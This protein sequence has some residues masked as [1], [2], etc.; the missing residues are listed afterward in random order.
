MVVINHEY[1]L[2]SSVP[3]TRMWKAVVLDADNLI[4]KIMPQAIKMSRLYRET[5]ELEA[6]R[7]PFKSAKHRI[8][9]V[10]EENHIF[11]Y[12]IIEGDPLMGELESIT[13]VVKIE[14]GL[15]GE[16]VIKTTSSYITKSD[17]HTITED[18]IKKGKDKAEAI[19]KAVEAHLYAQPD[20]YN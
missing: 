16:S 6:L 3:P 18:K 9:G 7:S 13:H 5:E 17:N 8:D 1:K 19:I 10:D 14:A 11:K 20:A 4:P 12:S 15:N 2:T